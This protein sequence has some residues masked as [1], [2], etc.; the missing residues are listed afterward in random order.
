MLLISLLFAAGEPA[1]G[2]DT[3]D[4]DKVQ[5]KFINGRKKCPVSHASRHNAIVPVLYTL[6]ILL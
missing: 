4:R 6:Y 3:T 5:C 1:L 2:E